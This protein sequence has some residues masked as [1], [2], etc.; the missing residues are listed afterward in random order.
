MDQVIVKTYPMN[1]ANRIR[2]TTDLTCA[3]CGK[4]IETLCECF[5]VGA[6]HYHIGCQP[7]SDSVVHKVEVA[8]GLGMEDKAG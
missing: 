7:Q 4:A 1:E 6:T 3:G 8:D 5:E 2:T